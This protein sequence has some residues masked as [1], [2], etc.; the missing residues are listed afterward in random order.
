MGSA[1]AAQKVTAGRRTSGTT[2]LE[3]VLQYRRIAQAI[4]Y[5]PTGARVLDIGCGDGSLFR[6]LGARLWEGLGLDPSL[7]GTVVGPRYRLE[8]GRVPEDVPGQSLFDVITLLAVLDKVPDEVLRDLACACACHLHPGG[9][10]IVTIA[11][12]RAG[13][14]SRVL[15]RAHL[16]T[17]HGRRGRPRVAV[18]QIPS[19]FGRAGLWT[20]AAKHFELGYNN[21]FVFAKSR[22]TAPPATPGHVSFSTLSNA[23]PV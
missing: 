19:V 6:R 9:R 7:P 2:F 17:G 5:V 10:L 11:S 8:R 16:V 3:R 13:A 14:I 22:S 12:P 23:T 21:L 1:M 18:A 4:P 15:E 20:E